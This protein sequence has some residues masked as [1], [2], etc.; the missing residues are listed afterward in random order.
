MKGGFENQNTTSLI[1]YCDASC[2]TRGKSANRKYAFGRVSFQ[3]LHH[4]YGLKTKAIPDV[5]RQGPDRIYLR[6]IVS[7]N[8]DS[9]GPS[10]WVGSKP[11]FTAFPRLTR[12]YIVPVFPC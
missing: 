10:A 2:A 5:S 8:L 1:P 9:F 6:Y 12:R 11:K 7:I 3:L 4:E